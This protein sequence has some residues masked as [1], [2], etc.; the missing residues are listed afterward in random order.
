MAELQDPWR[1][2]IRNSN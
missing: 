1:H 2:I